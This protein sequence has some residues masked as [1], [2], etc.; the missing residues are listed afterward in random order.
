VSKKLVKEFLVFQYSCRNQSQNFLSKTCKAD[1]PIRNSSEKLPNLSSEDTHWSERTLS[2]RVKEKFSYRSPG[3][4]RDAWGL[5][6]ELRHR[7]YRMSS[8]QS[9]NCPP[10]SGISCRNCDMRKYLRKLRGL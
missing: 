10:R 9:G 6:D 3:D 1:S 2:R 7:G 8:S 5:R 4:D